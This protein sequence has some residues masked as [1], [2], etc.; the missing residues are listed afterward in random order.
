MNQD[1]HIQTLMGFG[2]THLQAKTYLAL[3]RTGKADVNTISKFS[4]IV[5]QDIYCIVPT[6]EK[7]G[8]VDKI[9]AKP[10]MYKATPIKEGLS[11]LL[12][13][14]ETEYRELKKNSSLLLDDFS[15]FEND[16]TPHQGE[17]TQ[18]TVTSEFRLLI[19]AHR[20]L[21]SKT[22]KSVDIIVASNYACPFIDPHFENHRNAL[23]RGIKISV[24]VQ[25]ELQTAIGKRKPSTSPL[26]EVR[27]VPSFARFGMHIFDKKEATLCLSI[28]RGVPSLWSNN[29]N[30]M[31]LANGYFADMWRQAKPIK[32]M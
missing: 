30:L 6:L 15:G 20:E 16:I 28:D 21:F 19:K 5:R 7:L 3:V 10:T 26:F 32:C 22:Q 9:I 14:K 1:K 8:L 18:F 12:Q 29:P 27:C 23:K 25:G 31:E 2:L 4:N 11:L 13:N 24:L 17:K